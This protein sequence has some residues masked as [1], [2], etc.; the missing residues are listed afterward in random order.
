M[1]RIPPFCPTRGCPHNQP[2]V[3]NRSWFVRIGY[4][5]NRSVGR[6]QRFRCKH[7]GKSFSTRTFSVEYATHRRVDLRRLVWS[8]CSASGIRDVAREFAVSEKVILNRVSRLARQAMGLHSCLTRTVRLTEELV[9]DGFESFVGSQYWPNAFTLLVG[10]DSQYLYSV[11]YAQLRRKGRMTDAQRRRRD[12][13][14]RQVPLARGQVERSFARIISEMGWLWSR[15]PRKATL[16]LFTDRHR[17]YHRVITGDGELVAAATAGRFVHRRI[18]SRRPRTRSNPLFAV[19]YFDREVRKD[20]ASHARETVQWSR[21]VNNAM[22][23]MWLYGV[24]HNCF[25]RRRINGPDQ[26]TH[27]EHAGAPAGLLAELKRHF[28]TRRY[29]FSRLSLSDSQWLTWLRGW[30]TPGKRMAPVVPAYV[31]A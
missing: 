1:S 28:F 23:R 21:D 18:D 27:A 22:D 17:S 3:A 30:P 20:V 15:N 14:N 4:Y 7:C 26:R 2:E 31:I 13:L 8:L 24:W 29:F 16:T 19:N 25:K 6:V 11:D 12:A 9:A 5:A 10:A